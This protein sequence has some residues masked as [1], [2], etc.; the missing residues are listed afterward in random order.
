MTGFYPIAFD[1]RRG[2][3]GFERMVL[4]ELSLNVILDV[5]YRQGSDGVWPQGQ[6][7]GRFDIQLRSRGWILAEG[8]REDCRGQ[9]GTKQ[10][11]S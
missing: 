8:S 5:V 11:P 3:E 4:E 9:L 2:S 10:A 6:R 1:Q 7:R